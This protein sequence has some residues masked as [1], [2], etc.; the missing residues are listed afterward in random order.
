MG[1]TG[2][3]L[4]ADLTT[5][6]KSTVPIYNCPSRRSGGPFPNP[7][8]GTYNS[9]DAQ[10]NAVTITSTTMA[11]T[12]YAAN[13]GDQATNEN[14]AGPADYK[15]GLSS[16]WGSPWTGASQPTGVVYQKSLIRMRDIGKGT[17]NVYL[18]GERY[19]D[20]KL[21]ETGSDPSDNE[22][23]YVGYDN[24][25]YRTANNQPSQD[26]PGVQATDRYGSA[27]FGGFNMAY[28]DGHVDVI[29]YD[30]NLTVFKAGGNRH[31]N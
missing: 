10:G 25:L 5:L 27:H 1:K 22:S 18:A 21:Y 15:T 3:A 14:G 7:G 9:A 28:C 19:I 17:S 29:T 16:G 2:A 23:M 30:V 26:T 8:A 11:R 6:V 24:D 13:C 12:D 20:A 31:G 4:T